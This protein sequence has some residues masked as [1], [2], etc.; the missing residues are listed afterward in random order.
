MMAIFVV[1]IVVASLFPALVFSGFK[2]IGILKGETHGTP[3]GNY[4]RRGLVTVQ[5]VSS[6]V[7]IVGTFTVYQ[8]LKFMRNFDLE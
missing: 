4:A 1:G 3:K 5:F 2:P 6:A 7:M 8:Q